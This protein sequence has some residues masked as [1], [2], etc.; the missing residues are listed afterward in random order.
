MVDE[1][2]DTSESVRETLPLNASKASASCWMSALAPLRRGKTNKRARK[3]MSL[4]IW[5]E[6]LKAM[7]A[8]KRGGVAMEGRGVR[9][10]AMLEAGVLWLWKRVFVRR[11]GWG[12]KVEE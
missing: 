4:D 3:H 11:Y 8:R 2:H 9:R 12:N 6:A 7:H 1:L 10:V 5:L